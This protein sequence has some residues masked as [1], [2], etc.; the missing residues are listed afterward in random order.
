MLDER[1]H[2]AAFRFATVAR[3]CGYLCAEIGCVDGL[4]LFV[5]LEERDGTKHFIRRIDGDFFELEAVK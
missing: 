5:V 4:V 2:A 1:L 3:A